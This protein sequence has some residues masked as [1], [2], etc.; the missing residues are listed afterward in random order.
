AKKHHKAAHH[1]AKPA[2]QPAA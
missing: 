2:V 1:A